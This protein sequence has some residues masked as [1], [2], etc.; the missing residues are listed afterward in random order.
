MSVAFPCVP[1][2]GV[3]VLVGFSG[4]LDSTVLLHWLANAPAQ[5]LHGLEAIHVH[6]GLHE[7][8][9]AWSA[10]CAAFCA[11]RD[12]PLHVV[13]VQV[14]HNSGR[15]LEAAA[16][17]ARRAAFAQLL[18]QG[19]YLALAH[20]R[21]DQAET[22]LLRALRGS[23][24]GLAAMRPL[25]PFAAGQLWRPLLALSRAQLLDYA[26]QHALDWIEDPSNADPRHDRNFLRLHVLPLLHQRW[27]QAAAVLARNAALAAANGDLLD[28]EDA[29]LLPD[30]LDPDGALDIIGLYVQPPARR[31]RLLRAWCARA[32]VPPLPERGVQMIERDLLP[33]GHDSAACFVWCRTEIRRWRLRLYLHRPQPAW[34][35]GWQTVWSG[36]APLILPDGGQLRLESP[37][38]TVVPGFARPL[39]VRAR[40]GGERLVLPGRTHSHLLK[41]LLQA[42]G[43]PPWR[44]ASMPLLCEG[45]QILAAGDRLL[46]AP[47]LTWLHTHGLKLR[48]ESNNNTLI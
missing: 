45:E 25:T 8:A 39:C 20:H 42:A 40:R 47:L 34:P 19:Q 18:Q 6:H 7:H 24:D 3:P 36:T 27:P 13:R 31:A 26:R 35:P 43:I 10:H 2:T 11:P 5:H 32:G 16:R 1:D 12:I 37:H 9:D 29:V 14:C 44:R 21:D 23:G 15:G 28:A 41:H 48:W 30:L 46:A 4:G 22:W 38:Q 33:A 17:A